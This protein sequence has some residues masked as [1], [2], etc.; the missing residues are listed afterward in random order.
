MI[1]R[2][3][4]STLFPYTTL[5]RSINEGG[6]VKVQDGKVQYVGVQ[7]SEKIPV[8][9][10]VAASG[11]SGHGSQPRKDNPVLH[12]A[13]AAAKIAVYQGPARPSAIVRQDFEQA[14]KN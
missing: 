6:R 8:N 5:F 9:V 14:V 11:P 12:L 10:Q 3:P 7:A 2:P 1:R 13:A 4:R